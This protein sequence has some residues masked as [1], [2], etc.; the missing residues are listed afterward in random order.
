MNELIENSRI[1]TERTR[2]HAKEKD[3]DKTVID[4]YNK[5]K[6]LYNTRV[7]RSFFQQTYTV[8]LPKPIQRGYVRTFV[9]TKEGERLEDNEVVKKILDK[10]NYREYSQYPIFSDYVGKKARKWTRCS[11][12]GHAIHE[13]RTICVHEYYELP[14]QER[15]YFDPVWGYVENTNE[16]KIKEYTFNLAKKYYK[17]AILPNMIKEVEVIDSELASMVSFYSRKVEENFHRLQKLKGW[18]SYCSRDRIDYNHYYSGSRRRDNIDK[19][20]FKA[21]PLW[22]IEELSEEGVI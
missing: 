5:S 4:I 2:K 22:K 15:K 20:L 17:L 1:R 6:K 3:I 8:E 16:W 21:T 12:N 18:R 19:K 11:E 10:I 13:T 7:H 14:T 9:L